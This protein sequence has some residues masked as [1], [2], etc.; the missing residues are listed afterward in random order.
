[1]GGV[2]PQVCADPFAIAQK[3]LHADGSASLR[4][5]EPARVRPCGCWFPSLPV[6][7]SRCGFPER[8]AATVNAM[9]FKPITDDDV[10]AAIVDRAGDGY[11]LIADVLPSLPKLSHADRRRAVHRA[12][13]RGLV[14]Q[15]R[16]PD[17]RE[18]VALASEG[19][20][21]LRAA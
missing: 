14:L 9:A 16:G 8:I 12:V 3:S 10:L 19:W 6:F 4:R 21:H 18:H 11:C 15:R 17:G 20:R 7:R 5:R 13:G 2:P 1:M